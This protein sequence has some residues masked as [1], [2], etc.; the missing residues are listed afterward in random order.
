MKTEAKILVC[1]NAPVSIFPVYNGK[2]VSV[3]KNKDD[4]S[5]K[6]FLKELNILKK[7]LN[8]YYSSVETLAIDRNVKKIM[9]DIN[10]YSP[11]VIFNFVESVEGIATYEYCIAGLYELLDYEYTGCDPI[12][13][14]NCLNKSRTKEILNAFGIKTPLHIVLKPGEKFT[15]KDI[16]L[17]Y[18]VILKLLT[19]DA[20]IGI[21]EYSVVNNYSELKKQFRFLSETYKEELIIEEYIYGRELNVAVLGNKALPVSE[22]D[23]AGLPS[24][25][26][27]IVTYDGKWIENSL[28][29]KNT[30]PVCPAKLSERTRRMINNTALKAFKALN[31]R[32]Y[33]RIDIRLSKRNVPYVIEVNP[34][35]DIS[36]DSG[37][38]RAAKAAGLSHKE[39]L[40]TIANFAFER[41]R[42]YDPKTQAV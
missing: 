29:Y 10:S 26:P 4:L 7:R 6:S 38:A 34:N 5:E 24:D 32:D 12:S 42:K 27:K 19:E 16:P 1:Y 31:C 36:T 40:F 18:P 23:F 9:N 39:L 25:L 3:D 2:P 17:E 14:G 15:Q 33:A 22:I 11:D 28:Y 35:P 8:Q 30:K 13:L 41:K 20:S 21:S 37:F